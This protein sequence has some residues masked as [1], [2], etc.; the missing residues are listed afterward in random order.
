[1]ERP[2]ATTVQGRPFALAGPELKPGD[3]APDFH[4]VDSA[5]K[6]VSLAETGGRVRIFSVLPSLD[7]PVCDAQT[8]RF[9]IEAE[10]LPEVDIFTVS[11][12]LPFA[13]RRWC[14]Q[15]AVDRVDAPILRIR[16]CDRLVDRNWQETAASSLCHHRFGRLCG[17]DAGACEGVRSRAE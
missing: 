2:G 1:M 12:D 14:Q 8:R 13:Q 10:G 4:V 5:N 15:F 7:T 11:M 16:R 9:N 6:P 3:K 17:S